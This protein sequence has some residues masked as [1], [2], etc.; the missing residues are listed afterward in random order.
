MLLLLCGALQLTQ[1]SS[2][3]MDL[4]QGWLGTP[5]ETLDNFV[6]RHFLLSWWARK[7]RGWHLVGRGQGG[8]W[9]T[10]NAHSSLPVTK[11]DPV[12][13]VLRSKNYG[14]DTR[15]YSE[16]GIQRNGSLTHRLISEKIIVSHSINSHFLHWASYCARCLR[17]Q[18]NKIFL[19]KLTA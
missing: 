5:Q 6:W 2:R 7:R 16:K 11:N 15:A 8:H 14:L 9:P 17:H 12:Q 10:Y 4:K 3:S 19:D 18:N 13:N 1:E